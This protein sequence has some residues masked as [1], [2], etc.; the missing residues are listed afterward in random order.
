MRTSQPFLGFYVAAVKSGLGLT[1][2]YLRGMQ[3][4]RQSQ[5]D[6]I[7][8]AGQACARWQKQAETVHDFDALHGFQSDVLNQTMER[9]SCYWDKIGHDM[10]RLQLEF[11][12]A[13]QDC[14]A[15]A[16][17]DAR[18]QVEQMQASLSQGAAGLLKPLAGLDQ[19]SGGAA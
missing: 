9:V 15:R 12:G 10:T 16:T 3:R 6:Q 11:S 4:I 13:V 14:S 18:Q 8:A 17:Q 7:G 1:D 2:T 19:A 5:I